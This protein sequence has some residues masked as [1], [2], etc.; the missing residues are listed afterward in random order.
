MP[1]A[2]VAGVFAEHWP[3]LVAVL[4]RDIGDLSLAED[5]AQDAFVEAAERWPRD[6]TPDNPAGWLYRTAR[7]RAIDR[8]RRDLAF[9]E[10]MPLIAQPEST[11]VDDEVRPSRGRA[12]APRRGGVSSSKTTRD[13]VADDADDALVGMIFGCCHPALA[14]E[15]RVALTLRYVAG[16]TT[17]Q[18]ARAFLVPTDTMAKRLTRAKRKIAASRIPFAVPAPDQ[19]G[20]RLDAVL[21]VFYLLFTEGHAS[22]DHAELVRGDLCDEARWL[23]ALLA[24][25]LP[26]EP[27]VLGL[28]AL[29]AF[30]DARRTARLRPD[31]RLALLEDQDRAKWNRDDIEQ[32][33]ALLQRAVELRRVGQYQLQ[34]AIAAAHSSAETYDE[35]PWPLI[36]RLYRRLEAMHPTPVIALGLGVAIAMAEG[37]DA[38]L[39]FIDHRAPASALPGYPYLPA[40]RARLLERL[41]RRAEALAAYDHAIALLR[42]GP[43]R[44]D[45]IDRRAALRA[46]GAV[47]GSSEG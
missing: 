6:G 37:P 20:E 11:G 12:S 39:T 44:D 8:I 26:R 1:D 22:R 18:I 24:R 41:D 42:D 28:A 10:R 34:A 3:R 7:R 43:E 47:L 13:G 31:G 35:T 4:A 36:V 19:L 38:G 23:A 40:A 27:E 32:G 21:G 29:L 46:G 25:L 17:E 30:T 9:A 33:H 16:L 5:C 14:N 15:V 45:L 2:E